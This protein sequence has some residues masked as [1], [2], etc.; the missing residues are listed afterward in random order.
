MMGDIQ[1]T[2]GWFTSTTESIPE[3]RIVQGFQVITALNR[4]IYGDE[5]LHRQAD[6]TLE[7]LFKQLPK[8]ANGVVGIRFVPLCN[9]RG[10]QMM[11]AYGTAVRATPEARLEQ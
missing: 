10:H 7:M 3:C 1:K 4:T 11:M 8:G 5:V 9:E 6:D 2:I